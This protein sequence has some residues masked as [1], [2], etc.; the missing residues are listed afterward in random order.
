MMHTAGEQ[1]PPE[2]ERV[3]RR[4]SWTLLLHPVVLVALSL[5]VAAAALLTGEEI[6]SLSANA[7]SLYKLLGGAALLVCIS[8]YFQQQQRITERRSEFS[9]MHALADDEL[10]RMAGALK[11]RMETRDAAEDGETPR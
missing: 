8:A 6:L 5:A 11:A 1:L 9:R 3:T 10:A 4:H 2:A 7:I